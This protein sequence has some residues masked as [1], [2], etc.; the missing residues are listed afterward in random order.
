MKACDYRENL[1]E[2]VTKAF[3]HYLENL[4]VKGEIAIYEQ[5]LLLASYFEGL[6]RYK[7]A[8]MLKSVL[9]L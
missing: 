6:F 9:S 2:R 1:F 8:K 3:M 4:V 7:V 5:L